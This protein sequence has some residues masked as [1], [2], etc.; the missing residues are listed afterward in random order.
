MQL[1]PNFDL[2]QAWEDAEKQKHYPCVAVFEK[3][4]K[5]LV[6]MCDKHGANKS[7]DMVDMCMKSGMYPRPDVLLTEFENSGRDVM[8]GMMQNN[9]LMYAAAVATQQ[10]IPVV[11]A[12]L[13]DEQML[14]VL[15]VQYPNRIFESADLT[16]VLRAGPIRS[17]GE[18]GEMGIA[19]NKYGR[20][21]FMLQNIA[22][23]LN[24][25]DVVFAIFGSGHFVSQRLALID[26]MGIPKYITDMPNT[27]GDFYGLKINP[28]KLIDFETGG[29]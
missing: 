6:Y 18:F 27:R 8:P 13:S 29:L 17:N 10:N 26:M 24:K 19:L 7:F 25:Y 16:K 20:D 9:S 2:L 1:K 11:F 4:G 5:T 15:R 22:T 23:A 28:I 3:D 21:K 12:D 14:N